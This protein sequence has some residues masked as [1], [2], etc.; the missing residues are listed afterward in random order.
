MSD[1]CYADEGLVCRADHGLYLTCSEPDESRYRMSLPVE[2]ASE[3]IDFLS[4][5][6]GETA[7]TGRG[8]RRV[9]I[10]APKIRAQYKAEVEALVRQIA[11][12]L[13]QG[14]SPNDVARWASEQRRQI[15]NRMRSG[16]GLTTRAV[17]EIRDWRKYGRGGRT[18]DNLTRY[19]RNQGVP[20]GDINSRI[21]S[22]AQRSNTGVNAAMKGA[23]YLRHGGRV[24]IVVGVTI[25]VARIWN[26]SEEEL[27]RVISE[28][29]GG[30]IGG[31]LG[32]SAGVGLC[33]VFGIATSGWGLL[34]CGVV[35]GGAGGW[36]GSELSGAAADKIFYTDN[37]IPESQ[38]GQIG[39]EIPA[40]EIYDLP[41]PRMCFAPIE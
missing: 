29:L 19:Y 10:D 1:A 35:G 20:A 12:R 6:G 25:S 32:A 13:E 36:I 24:L 4:Q 2:T 22:G 26:A 27:P 30:F 21:L 38:L 33:I 11:D 39:I 16:S 40:N 37:S 9:G 3:A 31:G 23:A 34:A 15:V 14:Q 18:Y 7:G 8:M 17:Y 28:E 41:P 5:I